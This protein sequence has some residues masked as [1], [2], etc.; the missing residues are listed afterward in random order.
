ML[1]GGQLIFR[2]LQ[3]LLEELLVRYGFLQRGLCG[4]H[5]RQRLVQLVLDLLGVVGAIRFVRLR[6]RRLQFL[7]KTLILRFHGFMLALSITK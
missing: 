4:V 7:P 6:A 3:L 1:N 2:F 5:L